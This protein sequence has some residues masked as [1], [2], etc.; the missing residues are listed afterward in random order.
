[1]KETRNLEFK[2]NIS[3]SFL[4][5]VSAFASY[6]GGTIMFGLNDSGETVGLDD[7][8]KLCLK[9]ENKINDCI[10][11]QPEYSLSVNPRDNTIKLT[12]YPGT[13]KPY[14]Y[15]SK[16]Y[17]RNDTSTVEVDNIE[18]ERLILEGRNI[19]FEDLISVKQDLTF[20]LL[21]RNLK[22]QRGLENFNLDILK[23]LN[24]YSNDSGYNNAAAI[25]ADDNDFPGIDIAIFGET[26]SIIK[27]RETLD[28]MS[29]IQAYEAA[30]AVFRDYYSYEEIDG[31]K[32]H[33]VE[34]V[35][36]TAFRE[37][38]ANAIVHRLWDINSQIRIFM[39]DDRIEI[40]SPGGLPRGL[41]K[42]EYV[43]GR[44]SILRNPILANVFNRLNYIEA[45]GTGIRRIRN[46]YSESSAKPVFDA[47][48]NTVKVTLPVMEFGL[49]LS[50]DESKVYKA[51]SKA[52]AKPISEIM[53]SPEIKF[54]KSKVTGLLKAMAGKSLVM[55]EGNGKGTK[56]RMI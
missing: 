18:L 48:D 14:F 40:V 2:E 45:F 43:E 27:K 17:K 31:S 56:Y 39:F 22:E 15:N 50:T 37:A 25:L 12:V 11:P 51:L 20:A 52:K 5:T 36:E 1:M 42:D 7:P 6:D 23:T 46:A 54:G 55:I 21:E 10:Q 29:I 33:L 9:I 32:R 35:P 44:V 16:V 49:N 47:S 19:S 38:V 53:T 26:I 28:H 41:S 3:N 34:M 13:N 8:D 30:V 4:K 24:L